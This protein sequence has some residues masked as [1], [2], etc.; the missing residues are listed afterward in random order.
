MPGKLSIMTTAGFQHEYGYD[1]ETKLELATYLLDI[2][3]CKN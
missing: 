1:H 2:T 3:L